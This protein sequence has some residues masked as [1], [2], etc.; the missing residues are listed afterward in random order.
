[1]D[2]NLSKLWERAEDKEPEVQGVTK[3]RLDLAT[4]QQQQLNLQK[5][6]LEL[7]RWKPLKGLE[8]PRGERLPFW[9]DEV[10]CHTEK[11]HLPKNFGWL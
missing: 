8:P 7:I 4:E 3:A 1:M 9:L 5:I 10:D 2:M 11:A 6:I